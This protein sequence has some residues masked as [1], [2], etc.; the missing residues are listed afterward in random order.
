MAE[1]GYETF[2]LI[3]EDREIEVSYQERWLSSEMWHLELRCAERLPVTETGFRSAFLPDDVFDN[4][5]EV[6]E[7]VLSWLNEAA[8]DKAWKAYVEEARQLKLF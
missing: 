5:T 1:E 2:T 8:E 3:W 7:Y 6:Q 4:K